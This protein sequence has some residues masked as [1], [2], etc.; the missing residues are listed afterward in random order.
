MATVTG[1][2]AARM[3]EIEAASVVA[4]GILLDDLILTKHDGTQI[5]AGNVRGPRGF[6]GLDAA[7]GSVTVAG[8]TTPIRTS[9]GR[10]KAANPTEIDDVSTKSYADS[11]LSAAKLYSDNRLVSVSISPTVNLNALF[12]EGNYVQNSNTNATA[13]LNY[14]E[15][16]AGLLEIFGV[17]IV[18]QRYTTY[19]PG[20]NRVYQ[21]TYYSSAWGV[22]TQ[23]IDSK[24]AQT[25][26]GAKT[27]SSNIS[28]PN[29]YEAATG[30]KAFV[31]GGGT[32]LAL[33]VTF[34]AGR[35]TTAPTVVVCTYGP[36]AHVMARVST[37]ATTTTVGITMAS[38]PSSALNGTFYCLWIATN[39]P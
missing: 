23:L 7:P 21:R 36:F 3:L 19:T 25:I 8:N 38:N 39:A 17:S 13:A 20:L 29:V 10:M 32:T 12:A 28:A 22:W 16:N 18:Y 24:T 34:P 35:F 1:L 30:L 9:D 31:F 37:L 2:T 4:G 27:F 14:P 15:V 26:G 5:N 33:N 6:T 11:N